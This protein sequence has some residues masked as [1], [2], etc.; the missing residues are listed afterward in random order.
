VMEQFPRPTTVVPLSAYTG[1]RWLIDDRT[2]NDYEGGPTIEMLMAPIDVQPTMI[3][4]S[5]GM[6]ISAG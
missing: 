1:H 3:Y 4:H 2:F 5:A 6:E